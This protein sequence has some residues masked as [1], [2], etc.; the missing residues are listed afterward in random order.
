MDVEVIWVKRTPEYFCEKGWTG[1][2]VI[3]PSGAIIRAPTTNFRVRVKHLRGSA[4]D[5]DGV[6]IRGVTAI[7]F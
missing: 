7:R 4:V 3:C 2:S 5:R 1:G 6:I